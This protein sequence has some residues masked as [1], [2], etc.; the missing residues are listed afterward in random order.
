MSDLRRSVTSRHELYDLTARELCESM[1]N[2]VVKD[3][4]CRRLVA[5]AEHNSTSVYD[6][7]DYMSDYFNNQQIRGWVESQMRRLD[8][9]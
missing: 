1:R 8:L 6:L 4:D 5:W 2:H 9:L 7:L 3:T